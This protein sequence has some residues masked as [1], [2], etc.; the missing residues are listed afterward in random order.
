MLARLPL[1]ASSHLEQ[2]EQLGGVAR[3]EDLAVVQVLRAGGQAGADRVAQPPLA[4]PLHPASQLPLPHLALRLL[5]GQLQAAKQLEHRGAQREDVQPVREAAEQVVGVAEGLRRQV[6]ADTQPRPVIVWAQARR[7]PQQLAAGRRRSSM[8]PYLESPSD[9]P[10][11]K[12][13]PCSMASPKS[14]SL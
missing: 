9:V 2:V 10:A 4:R 1:A 11:R 3:Q 7:G 13:P 5:G 8:V 14:P 6:P 12:R